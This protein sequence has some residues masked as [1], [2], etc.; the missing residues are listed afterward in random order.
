MEKIDRVAIIGVGLIGGSLGLAL[1]QLAR[2][3]DVVGVARHEN[4][5]RTALI[6]GAIN[7][8][9]LD[10]KEAVKDA[11][12]V[13]IATPVPDIV[14]T[15]KKIMPHLK[16]GA[17]L[18]DVGSTKTSIVKEIEEICPSDIH[19]I[20]G[21][22]MAG[23]EL[24]GID[25]A[26]RDL[27]KNSTYI[28]TPTP[29]T[30]ADAFEA[31]HALLTKI[32]ARVISLNPEKH[33]QIAATISHLP[34]VVSSALVNLAVREGE[35][36]ENI[37]LLAAGGF[38]DMTRIA[39]SNPEMWVDICFENRQAV[40]E[41]LKH[42]QKELTDFASLIEKKDR[43]GLEKKLM[44]AQR[45]RQN[46]PRIS[47]TDL[48]SLYEFLIAVPNRP[49]VISDI[50]LAIGEM[51][52]NIEDIEIVHS[53]E[54]ESG[55]LKVAILGEKKAEKVAQVLEKKGYRLSMERAYK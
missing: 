29:N 42:F 50:T 11:D 55:F 7:K 1:R 51:G 37:L 16:R 34:H 54:S 44:D 49:G 22:P 8:A 5:L 48:A 39:T 15:T 31:L 46:L 17:I 38:Y 3:T 45:A 30:D 28:L 12:L 24:S 36:M 19:F 40:L 6:I 26:N 53:T 18:T 23:S 27:F 21:H 2:I 14:E 4:T 47:S 25:A 32:G 9:T 13:F 52:I 41:V 43:K 35:E 33:D 10:L 20:G